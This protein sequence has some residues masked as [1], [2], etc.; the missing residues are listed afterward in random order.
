MKFKLNG[1]LTREDVDLLQEASVRKPKYKKIY[2]KKLSCGACDYTWFYSTLRC[3]S[4][5]STEIKV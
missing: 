1:F 5:S 2:T 4:C 3:P